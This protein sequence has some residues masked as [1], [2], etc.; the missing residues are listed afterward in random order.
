MPAHT[1]VAESSSSGR[2]GLSG[3]LH[4]TPWAV[5]DQ[6]LISAANFAMYVFLARS[7]DKPAMGAFT[8][9]HS[10]L[11]FINSVQAG[12][13]TQPHNILGVTRRGGAYRRYTTATALA[14][15]A[16]AAAGAALSLLCWLGAGALGWNDVAA[17]LLALAPAIAAWQVQEFARRVLYTE[18]R[19]RDAFATDVIGYGGQGAAIALMWWRD[20]LTGPAALYAVAC[21]SAGAA[22]LGLWRIRRSLSRR[23]DT[24]AFSENWHFGKWIAGGEI[25]GY[26]LSVHLLWY[27]VAAMVD[28]AAAA[29]LGVV[30]RVFGPSRVL[31]DVFCTI[32]PIRLSRT[33]ATGGPAA[34][35][36]QMILAFLLAVPLLGGYCLLAAVF[37]RPLLHLLFGEQY[38]ESAPVLV[39]YSGAMFLSYMAMI[40]ATALRAMRLTR[41]LFTWQTLA[42]V[43]SFPVALALIRLWGVSGAVVDMILAYAA[44]MLLFVHTYRSGRARLLA[45]VRTC[46]AD[47]APEPT[48][49]ADAAGRLLS[50]VTELLSRHGIPYCITHGYECY[51]QRVS[52]DVDMVVPGRFVPEALARLLHDNRAA[53]G[54]RLVQYIV[55]D[56][57]Y[58]VLAGAQPD[59]TICFLRLDVSTAYIL[60]GRVFFSAEEVLE[61][62]RRHEGLCVASPAMEFA[63]IILRR[64]VKSALEDRHG[65]RLADL[66]AQ[67]TEGCRAYLRRFW[68]G[69]DAGMIE[70]AVAA[71]RWDEL[72]RRLPRLRRRLL[73]RAALRRPLATGGNLLRLTWRRLVRWCRPRNGFHLVL[74]GP[75]GAG[76]SSLAAA[77]MR[78]LAPAFVSAKKRSFP[79][80]LLGTP[81]AAPDSSP[82]AAPQRSWIHS[83]ARAAGYWWGWYGPGYL[84]TVHADLARCALV[85]HDRHL[86]DAVVDPVRYRY[87]GPVG[88]LRLV[89]RAVP[90]PDMLAVL[91]APPEVIRARKQDL[92]LDE[93]AR[94]RKL[95]QSLAAGFR[96][97]CIVDAALPLDRMV[98]H[99]EHL[100]LGVMADRAAA[101]LRLDTPAAERLAVEQVLLRACDGAGWRWWRIAPLGRGDQGRA[102][103]VT[104][105][106]GRPAVPACDEVVVKVFTPERPEVLHAVTDEYEALRCLHRTVNGRSFAGWQIVTPRPLLVCHASCAIV[107]TLVKGVSLNEHF[108]AGAVSPEFIDALADVVLQG[109][110]EYWTASGRIYGDLD[111]NNVLCDPSTH[112]ICFIDPGMPHRTY[113]CPDVPRRWYPASRDLGY[114]L[115][116]VASSVRLALSHPRAARLQREMIRAVLRRFLGGMASR[117]ERDSFLDEMLNCCR[118]HLRRIDVSLSPAGAARM[119]IR[120]LAWRNI[121]NL[122][123]QES[124]T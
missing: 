97:G 66:M 62:S 101:R 81:G 53:L 124:H 102:Y 84:W 39:L 7:L 118:V 117:E 71:G 80:G 19:L 37:A 52:S 121:E 17:L 87:G 32:L 6:M 113:E 44:T 1:N 89:A 107:M 91:D 104:A 54:A 29:V 106:D 70:T 112:T 22:L 63:C 120:R 72:R 92:P 28:R 46:A 67:D 51:P 109:L 82:H 23:V 59:G 42:C 116:D 58:F 26:W 79:P 27:L 35:H 100:M 103:L 68:S 25:V 34:M 115:F 105:D 5:A 88:L 13:I 18:G 114:A 40:I 122:V 111:F 45:E 4:Q 94:Q 86:L 15:I 99:V 123:A 47:R 11:L 77:V 96:R 43:L 12:L 90:M 65:Q 78:D 119:A 36:R 60:R 48:G 14:Q 16:L 76:K 31:A 2:A 33:L 85:V 98:R 3:I 41:D 110:R 69:P 56:T 38:P 57:H 9:V 50:R 20:T 83:V 73:R 93:I 24:A 55:A 74:L 108:C 8:L 64:T 10:A 30:H 49:A 95:Y 21:A 61:S 75:D